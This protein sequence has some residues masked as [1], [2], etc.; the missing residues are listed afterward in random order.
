MITFVIKVA[1]LVSVLKFRD[2]YG[3]IKVDQS[4]IYYY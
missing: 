3:R 1:L 2:N 4:I